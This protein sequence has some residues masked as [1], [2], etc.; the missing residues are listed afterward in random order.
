MGRTAA[1]GR[2]WA[3]DASTSAVAWDMAAG[4]TQ[5]PPVVDHR[6]K[7]LLDWGG[8]LHL[9]PADGSTVFTGDNASA[10]PPGC[11]RRLVIEQHDDGIEAHTLLEHRAWQ[12]VTGADGRRRV[13]RVD[14]GDGYA[15]ALTYS[16]E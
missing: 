13:S 9:E 7:H 14:L 1:A 4:A 11:R 8:H 10:A 3:L 15:A 12:I 6:E 2:V 5:A 16:T